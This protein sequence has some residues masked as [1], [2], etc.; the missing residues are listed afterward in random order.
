MKN[1]QQVLLM[2]FM[3]I[4]VKSYSQVNLVSNPSF[5]DTLGCPQGYPDLDTKC[6]NWKSFRATPDYL[7]NCS[8]IC[9]YYNQA[10]YQQPHRGQAYAG[11]NMYQANL[12]NAS[13]QIGIQLTSSLIIG[14]KYYISF[15]VS[16]AFNPSLTNVACNKIGALVTTYQYSDSNGTFV[17]P[18]TCTFH[19]NVIISDT[20]NWIKISGSFTADSS[21]QYLLI[22]NFYSDSYLDTI[23]YQNI[24]G[25]YDAYYYLDDVCLTTDSIYNE[26]WTG[27][28][29]INNKDQAE[30]FPNPTS[31]ILNI[32][33]ADN[34]QDVSIINSVGQILYSSQPASYYYSIAVTD[35]P[36]GIYFVRIKT[37][38]KYSMSIVNIIH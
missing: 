19:T 35:I 9:G 16:S 23:Q 17:L 11:F 7:N 14:T 27:V 28:E 22:G 34:I 20:L 12:P 31:D 2:M 37:E 30:I 18:D 6:Q 24:F 21:Y 3:A 15:Y 33:S 13:E 8:S 36:A 4:A 5:E 1:F 32:R 25:P 26:M 10:G 29:E 38:K